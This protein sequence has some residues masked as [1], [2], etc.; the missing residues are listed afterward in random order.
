MDSKKQLQHG[1]EIA[2]QRADVV[3]TFINRKLPI[4]LFSLLETNC[5]K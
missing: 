4:F 3:K 5:P 1:S 2:G